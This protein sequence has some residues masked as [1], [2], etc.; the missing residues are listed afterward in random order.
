MLAILLALTDLGARLAQISAIF[1]LASLELA[2]VLIGVIFVALLVSNVQHRKGVS[3]AG[4]APWPL[5]IAL[6]STS[7]VLLGRLGISALEPTVLWLAPVLLVGPLALSWELSRRYRSGAKLSCDSLLACASTWCTVSSVCLIVLSLLPIRWEQLDLQPAGLMWVGASL[8][9]IAGTAAIG[10]ALRGWLGDFIRFFMVASLGGLIVVSTPSANELLRSSMR[11]A[12][13]PLLVGIAI[14]FAMLIPAAALSA[15]FRFFKRMVNSSATLGRQLCRE[16]SSGFRRLTSVLKRKWLQVLG[17][18]SPQEFLSAQSLTPKDRVGAAAMAAVSLAFLAHGFWWA[19]RV[20]WQPTGHAA[21]L[22]MR[23]AQVGTVDHPLVGLVTS[24]G[25]IGK[26]SHLG[27][28]VMDIAAPFVR[29]FGVRLGA[30][31]AAT[32]LTLFCWVVIVWSAW[33]AAGRVAAV[34]AW[35]LAAVVITVPA[36]GAFWEANNISISMLAITAT[37]L[38]SWAATTATPRAWWLA[39]GLGSFCAQSYIPHALII[40]GPVLWSG[41]V[42][43][44]SARQESAAHVARR[45]RQALWVGVGVAGVAWFQPLLDVV[46]HNGGNVRALILE[47]SNATP[48]LGISGIPR[49][50]AWALAVPPRWGEVTKNFAQAGSADEFLKGSLLGGCLMGILLGYLWWRTRRNAANNERQLRIITLCVLLGSGLNMTQ[51]PQ[52]FL[53]SFQLAWLVVVSLF[54]WFSVGLSFFLALRSRVVSWIP[55]TQKPAFQVVTFSLSAVAV[56]ALGLSGPTRIE[57]VKDTAFTIDALVDPLVEQ[58]LAAFPSSE[59]VLVLRTGGRLNEVATDTLLS[60]LIVGGLNA[61]VESDPGG[62]NYGERRLVEEWIGPMIWITSALNPIKPQGEL[63]AAAS[64]P[65]WNA[66]KFTELSEQ[67]AKTVQSADNVELQPW[68][69]GYLLRYLSGWI[70]DKDVCAT[71]AAIR[72][73]TYPI[74]SLPPGLLMTLYADLAFT[75]PEISESTQVEIAGLIGQAPL[76]VWLSEKDQLGSIS[77]NNLLRDGSSCSL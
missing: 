17:F 46:L 19:Y 10:A 57:Q 22:M 68:V 44:G 13:L 36:I 56:I 24:L 43:A 48:S 37:I 15:V 52:E 1:A 58:T 75:S 45:S 60:N 21:T 61:R 65:G 11:P 14:G 7:C 71:A 40:A 49:G 28:L 5:W 27:P 50:I 20:G 69:D 63:L 66:E 73:G 39:V 9:L 54:V 33:R 35:V 16:V 51:L 72:S 53:R 67:V 59:E 76:E 18:A 6:V 26:G 8:M 38:A 29:I 77:S 64:V 32:S 30:L 4:F 70:P 55:L 2:V 12:L 23:A 62:M 74:G 3:T 25:G 42:I 31:L 47:V 41:I 34:A